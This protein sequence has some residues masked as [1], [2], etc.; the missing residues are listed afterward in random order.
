MR[1][2]LSLLITILI[3]VVL[4]ISDTAVHLRGTLVQPAYSC[5]PEPRGCPLNAFVRGG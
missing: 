1:D 3:I 2:E 4:V 5:L